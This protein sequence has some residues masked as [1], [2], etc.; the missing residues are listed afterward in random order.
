M[1]TTANLY[2]IKD[3]E[4]EK[5]LSSYLNKKIILENK[6]FWSKT[7]QNPIEIADIIAAYSDNSDN[8]DFSLWISLDKNIFI[9]ISTE[10][11]NQIIKYLFERYPY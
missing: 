1:N 5:F 7:F 10:N 11:C 4:I 9:K 8:F 6:L 2:S 3:E